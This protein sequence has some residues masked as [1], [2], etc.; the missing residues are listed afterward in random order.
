MKDLFFVKFNSISRQKRENTTRDPIVLVDG[1]EDIEWLTA[2]SRKK[3]NVEGEEREQ[4]ANVDE[5]GSS[6]GVATTQH[7]RKGGKTNLRLRKRKRLIPILDDEAEE[8]FTT[9]S[10]E[11]EADN[12]TTSLATSSGD[13][14]SN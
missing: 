9:S 6:Q 2:L 14:Y 1:D 7:K 11:D 3:I 4:V 10:S 5:G 13:D 12:Q 8:A